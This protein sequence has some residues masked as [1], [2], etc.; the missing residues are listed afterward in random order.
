MRSQSVGQAV[1]HDPKVNWA[2]MAPVLEMWNDKLKMG[3]PA[4]KLKEKG[5]LRAQLDPQQGRGVFKEHFKVIKCGGDLTKGRVLAGR[6]L[7]LY[8]ILSQSF[9]FSVALEI[10]WGALKILT[11]DSQLQGFW[12]NSAPGVWP[13]LFKNSPGDIHSQGAYGKLSRSLKYLPRFACG[14]RGVGSLQQSDCSRCCGT[15]RCCGF[16]YSH[17]HTEQESAIMQV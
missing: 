7:E 17:N 11:P 1:S 2:T 8:Q 16:S 12:L 6:C 10:T 4:E 15:R 14:G 5:C 9:L 3:Q 13:R